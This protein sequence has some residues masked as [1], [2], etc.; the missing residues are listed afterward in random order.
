MK[1]LMGALLVLIMSGS[2]MGQTWVPNTTKPKHVAS[3]NEVQCWGTTSKGERC[4]R[5]VSP[6]HGTKDAAGHWYCYQH[7][8][9]IK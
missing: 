9:Q 4:K 3:Q 8:K 2:A 7:A 6:E 5:Q 1:H